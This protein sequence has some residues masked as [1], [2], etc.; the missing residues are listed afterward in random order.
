MSPSTA[1]VAESGTHLTSTSDV[2]N[3]EKDSGN[4]THLLHQPSEMTTSTADSPSISSN[5]TSS[6]D[7]SKDDPLSEYF[8]E[9]RVKKLNKIAEEENEALNLNLGLPVDLTAY[10]RRNIAPTGIIQ[11][12]LR[13]PIL[14]LIR[15][16]DWL[17]SWVEGPLFHFWGNIVPL[18]LRQRITFLGWAIYFP[19]HKA[20]I[21]RR[22][23]LHRDVSL[24]YHALTTVMWWGR[25]F[26][27]TIKR[28][29]FSLSQ[30]HAC[31][32]GD[33]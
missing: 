17:L 11:K 28:M 7:G 10:T 30:L 27:I 16:F 25:L 26:P 15:I 9:Q 22:T 29:R 1:V 20:L 5:S 31:H 18:S 13:P 3:T 4:K 2:S 24:E 32:P 12:V 23:G 33:G 8:T 19:I 21:G 14:T 6:D